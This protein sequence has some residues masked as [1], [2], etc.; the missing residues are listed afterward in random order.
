MK[1]ILVLLSVVLLCLVGTA[2]GTMVSMKFTFDDGSAVAGNVVL[3]RVATPAD[4]QIGTY[5]LDA[6]GQVASDLTL[7]PAATY[8][9]KLLS[10]NGTLLQEVWTVNVSSAMFTA[11]LNTLPTGELDVVLSKTDS[12]IKNVQFVPLSMALP[13]TKFASC[14]STPAGTTGPTT[15]TGGG[16]VEGFLVAGQTFDC[17]VQVPVAGTYP[18][19]VR[20]MCG[21]SSCGSV[22]FEYPAGT[23]VGTVANIPYTGPWSADKY[24]TVSAGTV[25]LPQGTVKIRVVVDSV[26]LALNWFD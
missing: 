9:A 24:A 14:T 4:V 21:A 2:N 12:S 10:P 19:D 6:K 16:L 3:Y 18:L 11:A 23:R 25:A 22:H 17:Q 8:H 26:Y 15:D 20:A 1:K 5:T 13:Q 7:D